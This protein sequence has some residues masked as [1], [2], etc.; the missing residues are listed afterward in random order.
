MMEAIMDFKARDY[1]KAGLNM[2]SSWKQFQQALEAVV[3]LPPSFPGYAHIVSSAYCG[4]G[5]FHFMI[6]I[7]P[8]AFKWI[9]EA[10][11]FEGDRA[12][13]MQELQLGVEAAGY[14]SPQSNFTIILLQNFFFEDF[15]TANVL[16]EKMLVQFP[17][18]VLGLYLGGCMF[19]KQ[20]NIARSDE[21]F[22]AGFKYSEQMYQLQ[23]FVQSEL[24]YNSFLKL[25]WEQASV[26]LSG[27]LRDTSS[28]GFKAFIGWQLGVCFA[29]MGKDDET[30][31]AM[32]QLIPWVRK[33]YDYD[34]FAGRR[35]KVFLKNG[36]MTPVEKQ[37]TIASLLFE[38]TKFEEAV[39]IL[40]EAL[41][42][43]EDDKG[44]INK[45]KANCYH[46]LGKLDQAKELYLSAI[47]TEKN[48]TKEN[49]YVVP[50]SL[51]GIAEIF[52]KE[53]KKDQA[54]NHLKRAKGFSGYDWEQITVMKLKKAWQIVDS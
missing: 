50:Q 54:K 53:G 30:K 27:F 46:S 1:V 31:N 35:A 4:V 26:Q 44:C 38:A 6:S 15:A 48:L 23:L 16:L 40:D 43:T 13:G 39:K 28:Q 19:R 49:I 47:A 11:G 52:I 18:S 22:T 12:R 2:R 10:V 7:V 5:T 25:D 17:K 41:P 29:M 3:G 51:V 42:V 9:V 20:G 45:L 21:L 33:D 36:K 8:P 32:S 24:G 37:F 34:E 14:R